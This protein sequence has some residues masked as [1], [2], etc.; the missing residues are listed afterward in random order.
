MYH[1]DPDYSRN[2]SYDASDKIQ[3]KKE[4]V[5]DVRR[6]KLLMMLAPGSSGQS[7]LK[8]LLVNKKIAIEEYIGISRTYC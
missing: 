1:D 5:S 7:Q 2:K 8:Y 3:F 4:R 6:I